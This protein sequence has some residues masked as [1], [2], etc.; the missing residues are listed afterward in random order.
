MEASS[1][2]LY[3]PEDAV[4]D[5]LPIHMETQLSSGGM[6]SL[7]IAAR[8]ECVNRHLALLRAAG[9]RSVHLD[10]GGCAAARLIGRDNAAI[11]IVDYGP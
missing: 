10:V 11:A 1:C 2:L 4:I 7:L 5:Y 9:L 8:K 3:R 6:Q